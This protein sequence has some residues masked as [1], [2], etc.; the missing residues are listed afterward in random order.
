[1]NVRNRITKL[2]Q[3]VR[4]GGL[5]PQALRLLVKLVAR[6]DALF[7]PHRMTGDYRV[8]VLQRQRAYL[9]GQRGLSAKADGRGQWRDAQAGRDELIAAGMV[10]ASE[11]GGQVTSLFI[12]PAGDEMVSRFV[13]RLNLLSEVK[14]LYERF[15][16]IEGKPFIG[17]YRWFGEWAAFSISQESMT[18]RPSQWDP[19]TECVLPM[20]NAGLVVATSDSQYRAY[21]SLT[22]QQWPQDAPQRT[23]QSDSHEEV[24]LRAYDA[25]RAALERIEAE[26]SSEVFIQLP[27]SKW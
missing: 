6:R 11:S 2:E 8:A 7:W 19:L 22:G 18:G 3:R 16:A 27:N 23:Q 4:S 20:L 15:Q 14:E 17:P 24:Y 1:M 5:S 12:T 10:T 25:E 9:S 21:Y 26:D 13:S